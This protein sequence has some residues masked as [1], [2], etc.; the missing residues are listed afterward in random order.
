MWD[1]T[2]QPSTYEGNTSTTF[3]I[4]PRCQKTEPSTCTKFQQIDLDIQQK[5]MSCKKAPPVKSW[6]CQCGSRWYNC[7]MHMRCNSSTIHNPSMPISAKCK[8][9]KRKQP[10]SRTQSQNKKGIWIAI[11]LVLINS[12]KMTSDE[13]AIK[14]KEMNAIP[15]HSDMEPIIP[16]TPSC[17]VQLWGRESAL[18]PLVHP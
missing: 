6:N 13:Q 17:S 8:S 5:C 2:T 3:Y 11:N 1:A 14:E 16:F 7:S 12:F 15:Y 10:S 18:V 4:C 9:Q